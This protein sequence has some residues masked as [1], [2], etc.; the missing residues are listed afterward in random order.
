MVYTAE[1]LIK[2]A[3]V[4]A[5]IAVPQMSDE[6]DLLAQL[7]SRNR[8]PVL[9]FSSVSPT[10][11]LHT[12]PYFVQT[13][14]KDSSQVAPIVDIIV[15]FLGG[16][17]VVIVCEDSPYG[18]GIL[19]PLTEALQSSSVRTIDSV[20]VPIGVTDDHFDQM[21]YRLKDMSARLFVVNMRP[22][23]A[24]HLFS[25][26]K[27]AGMVTED[28]VWIA[29]GALGNVVDVLSPD[30]IDNLQGIL[31][32]RPYVQGTSLAR[33]KARFHLEN[34]NT[35]HVHTPS[36][37]LFQAYDTAWATCIASEIAGVSRLTIRVAEIDLS[38]HGVSANRRALLDSTLNT[39]FDGLTGDFKM[40]NGEVQPPSYEIVHVN[41]KG[42]L[43]VGLWTPPLSLQP[44][45]LSRKGYSF[46]NSRRSV[47]WREDTVMTSKGREKTGFPLNLDTKHSLNLESKRRNAR[48]LV[49]GKSGKL[50][51]SYNDKLL[52]IGV[53]QNEGFKAFVNVSHPYFFCKDNATRPSTTKQV[54]G[55]IIDVFETAMEKLQHPP[56]YDFCVFDGS[57]DELVGN[58]SLGVSLKPVYLHHIIL[59]CFTFFLKG[60]LLYL[61]VIHY[62]LYSL[63]FVFISSNF[64]MDKSDP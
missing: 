47:F 25:R 10:L 56:C 58:V 32:L 48:K 8:I 3:Q 40:V 17:E 7:G 49:G 16:H 41:R 15:S 31:T 19:Q 37:L 59:H 36:V 50:C 33:F 64:L 1:D 22:A 2:N 4:L 55:Y 52:R 53:P 21:L 39:T 24:V 12:V 61:S 43:G 42:A 54:T 14:P 62:D 63:H 11:H 44:Q 20:V 29:T 30:D 9:S 27:K 28:Y 38:I 26:A 6:A 35:D 13:S 60:T 57:Y 34:L 18:I 51:R 46:D 45:K 5:I 23:L